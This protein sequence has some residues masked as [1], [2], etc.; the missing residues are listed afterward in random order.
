[1]PLLARIVQ[2]RRIV[3][4]EE[5]SF[6]FWTSETLKL[7]TILLSG[8]WCSRVA[9]NAVFIAFNAINR[10][11]RSGVCQHM[12]LPARCIAALLLDHVSRVVFY[13]VKI[14]ELILL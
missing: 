1:M 3:C 8:I 6:D 13:T 11:L 12:Y 2:R 7:I 14:L 10:C 4:I 5:I 9:A